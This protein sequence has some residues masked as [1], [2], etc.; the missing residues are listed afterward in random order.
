MAENIIVVGGGIV[1]ASI[2]YHLASNGAKVTI[3]EK[4]IPASGASSKSFG[5]INA[6][7]A[8]TK[9]YYKLRRAA[10]FDYLD[11]CERIKLETA[12]KW[13]GSLWWEDQGQDLIDQASVL[14]EYG[15]EAKIIDAARF[16]ALEPNIANPPE[17]CIFGQIE[18]SADGAEMV[19]LLLAEATKFDAHVV[20]GCHVSGFLRKG[21]RIEGVETNFGNMRADKVVVATGA[22][23]QKLLECAGI[24]LPMDN[25][26]GVIVHTLPVDP[27]VN[28][29]ILS[30]DIHFRQDNSGRI[31][32]GEI[33]S[34]GGLNEAKAESPID[35][36]QKM[37]V[38]LK[39][40]LP[41]V[42]DLTVDRINVGMRP[43]PLDGLPAVGVP[44]GLSGIYVAV[45]HSGITL[46]PLIGRLVAQ[47][48]LEGQDADALSDFR[49][50]RLVNS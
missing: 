46:A 35:F 49:P 44:N 38:R 13:D 32:L 8:E 43:V 4:S 17:K 41:D 45:M 6:N 27:V 2:A 20:A 30:P 36:S 14:A 34:G 25:K 7:A 5:W 22:W 31:I 29:L 15:Y 33:F 28:H 26:T 42:A 50:D 10:I 21:N 11:L 18:G 48:M 39:E 40:R 47:E 19:R 37:L 3:L 12:V 24:N 16:T 9:S 1:G 23:S